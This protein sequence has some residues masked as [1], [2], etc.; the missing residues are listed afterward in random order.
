MYSVNSAKY[1][2]AGRGKKSD[3]KGRKPHRHSKV[4]TRTVEGGVTE[5]SLGQIHLHYLTQG[6]EGAQGDGSR[7]LYPKK[8]W[9][10]IEKPDLAAL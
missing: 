1:R 5:E 9:K 10:K 7:G 4:T 6:P 2:A 8:T 3:F